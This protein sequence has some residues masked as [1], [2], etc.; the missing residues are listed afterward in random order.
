MV[1]QSLA[2]GSRY[3][4]RL[5]KFEGYEESN[6]PESKWKFRTCMTLVSAVYDQLFEDVEPAV[7]ARVVLPA[8]LHLKKVSSMFHAVL[9]T[10]TAG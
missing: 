8:D 4:A 9:S 1:A 5:R 6:T 10:V 2:L 7:G 3:L